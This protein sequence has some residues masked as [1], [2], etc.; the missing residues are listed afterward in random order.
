M[1]CLYCGTRVSPAVD[2]LSIAV[3]E[4]VPAPVADDAPDP[5]TDDF[6][7]MITPPPADPA[8]YVA[9]FARLLGMDA[10]IARQ[11]LLRGRPFAPVGGLTLDEA[12][13]IQHGLA[14]LGVAASIFSE[15]MMAALPHPASA[16]SGE[17]H[18]GAVVLRM[19]GGRVVELPYDVVF[20]VV[21]GEVAERVAEVSQQRVRLPGSH[22][23]VHNVEHKVVQTSHTRRGRLVID[24]YHT[25]A[26]EAVRLDEDHF[27]MPGA[28]LTSARN[29]LLAFVREL[30]E[31]APNEVFDASFGELDAIHVMTR[32]RQTRG[33]TSTVQKTVS[34][35]QPEFDSYSA[36]LFLHVLKLRRPS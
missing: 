7:V 19:R 26:A 22:G 25:L 12:R 24:V 10:F 35:N 21:Q 17:H 34:D 6:L 29:N 30:R 4:L 2:G 31:R 11:R 33:I 27:R 18:D 9:A 14:E 28:P 16:V 32:S 36:S 23:A 5:G 15:A 13:G 3:D 20:L 8:G 1:R